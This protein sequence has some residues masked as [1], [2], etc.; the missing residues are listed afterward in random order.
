MVTGG[1]VADLAT[2]AGA[3]G[4]ATGAG[5]A[6]T[7]AAAA[8]VGPFTVTG[9]GAGAAGVLPLEFEVLAAGLWQPA[10][11]AQHRPIIAKG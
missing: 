9:A 11:K 2:A 1:S 7:G 3:G 5:V 4:V 6:A 10:S 8:S